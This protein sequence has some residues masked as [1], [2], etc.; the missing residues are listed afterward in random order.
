MAKLAGTEFEI[1]LEKIDNLSKLFPNYGSQ[2]TEKVE[3]GEKLK[4]EN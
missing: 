2:K 1:L 4:I 3:R